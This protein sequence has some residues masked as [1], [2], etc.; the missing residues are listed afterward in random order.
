MTVGPGFDDVLSA[1]QAGAAWA[2][3]T[4]YKDIN[5]ALLRYLRAKAPSVAEDLASEVW[6]SAAQKLQSFRGNEDGFRSWMF[7]IARR[8]VIDHVRQ[9]GRRR[10]DPVGQEH[11]DRRAASDDTAEAGMQAVS[12]QEA[13]AR[14]TGSLPPDQAEVVLLRIVAGFDVATVAE[15]MGRSEGSV[16]VL[17]HRALRRMAKQLGPVAERL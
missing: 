9:A 8:R 16:R 15:M 7:T 1:A 10:T 6:L 2:I 12:A 17:Q 14:L 5:P 3:E 11:F 4:L 13:I